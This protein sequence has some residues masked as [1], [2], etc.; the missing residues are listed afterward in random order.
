MQKKWVRRHPLLTPS[1][2]CL[3]FHY[4]YFVCHITH[5]INYPA[6]PKWTVTR[7][8]FCSLCSCKVAIEC[9]L[10]FF[11]CVL[12]FLFSTQSKAI[13]MPVTGKSLHKRV[14]SK[15]VLKGR[16]FQFAYEHFALLENNEALWITAI[17]DLHFF[18]DAVYNYQNNY[19]NLHVE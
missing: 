19:W 2:T 9:V 8:F 16:F 5:K 6:V 17:T 14:K 4:T 10:M 11:S 18:L 13:K 3:V 12:K 1:I 7:Y 15:Q